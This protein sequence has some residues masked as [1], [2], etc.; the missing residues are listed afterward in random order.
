MKW[1]YYIDKYVWA[2]NL[3]LLVI[4][5]WAAA[6][7]TSTSVQAHFM[8]PPQ[9]KPWK[10]ATSGAAGQEA[11]HPAS[12]ENIEARNLFKAKIKDEETAPLSNGSED[13]DLSPLELELKGI[14]HGP[15]GWKRATIFDKSS[16][17]T[18]YPIVG[19]E[20]VPGVKVAA[21][22]PKKVVLERAN[23]D[24]EELLLDYNRKKS[25]KEE[26]RRK[27][28]GRRGRSR[29]DKGPDYGKDV[30]KISETEYVIERESFQAAL[31]NMNELI[32]QMLLRPNFTPDRQVDGFR[33]YRLRPRSLFI[34]LGLRNGDVL[35]R[36]NGVELDDASKGM[37]LLQTLKDLSNFT[38]DLKR[39]TR[40]MTF[41]Y[42]VK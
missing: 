7:V 21:I 25:K 31:E 10:P 27:R 12:I 40:K 3:L 26:P 16:K 42:E 35:Q 39:G 6:R 34:K 37:G 9:V 28:K 36:V 4:L 29:A 5:G 30:K 14:I 22:H 2:L 18:K 13:V 23:G 11:A 8:Q 38:I 41:N 24:R 20:V 15:A 17:E 19:D 1:S 32:T 33:V